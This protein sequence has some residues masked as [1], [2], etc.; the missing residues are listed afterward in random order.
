MSSLS[1][2]RSRGTIIKVPDGTSGIL[3][4]NGAQRPFTLEGVWRSPVAP[5]VNMTV[6]VDLDAGGTIAAITV[7]N[8]KEVVAQRLDAALGVAKEQGARAAG[9]LLPTLRSVAARMGTVPLGAAVLLWI[10]WFLFRAATVDMG[11][12]LLSFS[13]WHLLGTDFNNPESVAGA[14]KHGL[15]SLIGIVAIAAPFAAPLLQTTWARFLNAAPF[16]YFVCAFIA[17]FL[18]EHKAFGELAKMDVPNPFSWSALILVPIASTVVLGL[19]ALREPG[20]AQQSPTQV[21]PLP[22]I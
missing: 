6:D 5:A 12:G 7:V 20:A 8:P 11:G 17:I 19:G 10:S 14:G 22:G 16:A 3:F 2:E 15:F 21:K 18:N 9:I 4:L 1:A 13:F